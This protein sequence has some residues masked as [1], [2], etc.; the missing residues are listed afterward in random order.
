MMDISSHLF[1]GWC[2]QQV[3]G[4]SRCFAGSAPTAQGV[5]VCRVLFF[6]QEVGRCSVLYF[7]VLIGFTEAIWAVKPRNGHND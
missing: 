7:C 3:T 1:L 2:A 4:W 6:T 5:G